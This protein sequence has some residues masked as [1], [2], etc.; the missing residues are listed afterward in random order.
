MKSLVV[1]IILAVSVSSSLQADDTATSDRSRA[2]GRARTTI[3]TGVAL[4]TAGALLAPITA[5][6]SRDAP[7]GAGVAASVGL[8]GAGSALTFVGFRQQRKA[9]QPSTSFGVV[10]GQRAGV[11]VRRSW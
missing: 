2:L 6:E 1:A 11:V 10:V 3:W 8:I 7:R 9:A 4:M 5:V